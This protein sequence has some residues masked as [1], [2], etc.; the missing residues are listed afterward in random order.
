[1]SGRPWL[2]SLMA[3]GMPVA[4]LA[5][6]LQQASPSSARQDI[7]VAVAAPYAPGPSHLALVDLVAV[8]TAHWVICQGGRLDTAGPLVTT[9]RTRAARELDA[10]DPIV[11][12]AIQA[13]I[14]DRMEAASRSGYR[15]WCSEARTRLDGALD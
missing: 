8:A 1:M 5:L 12:R 15:A 10:D 4:V 3:L 9:A 11:E 14:E 6:G 13:A 7:A 2:S